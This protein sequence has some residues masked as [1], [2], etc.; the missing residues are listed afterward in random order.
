MYDL[1]KDM[2][3][4]HYF[5]L[6]L[7][8]RASPTKRGSQS[9]IGS[10]LYRNHLV[11]ATA[12]QRR[13]TWL[14]VSANHLCNRRPADGTGRQGGGALLARADVAALDEHTFPW[15]CQAYDA[16]ILVL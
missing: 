6:Q 11:A 2:R 10:Y 1:E 12:S 13:V 14:T 9:A 15:C 16:L 7:L 5:V 4:S 3:N 8:T